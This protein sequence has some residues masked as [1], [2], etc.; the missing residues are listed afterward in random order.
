[1]PGKVRVELKRTIEMKIRPYVL[2]DEKAVIDLWRKCD[3][4]RPQNDP[5]LDIER[6]MRVNPELFLVGLIEGKVVATVMGGYEGHRGW[7]NYLGV[8]PA[9]QRHGLGGQMML[10]IEEQLRRKGSPKI[11]LQVRND[12]IGVVKFYQSL[13]YA[14]DEVV[15]MGKRLMKD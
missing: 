12:N 13:G 2:V 4:I 11:N 10:A 9:C 15:S 14:V 3:L 8:D 5:G 1:M 7:I 6:K